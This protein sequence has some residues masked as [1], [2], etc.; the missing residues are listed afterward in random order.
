MQQYAVANANY[1]M[2][3][4]DKLPSFHAAPFLCGGITMVGALSLCDGALEDGDTLV[5]SG[6]GGG[7]GHLG[8]QIASN[9]KNHKRLNV[10]AIDTGSAKQNPSVELG[11]AAFIDFKTED[12]VKK[13]MELANGKGADA[14]IVI[15]EANEAFDQAL[16][17]LRF[18]GTM[19][20]VGITK[21]D[22]R[23]PI[24][25]TDLEHRGT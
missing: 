7:L 8:L 13:V 25:P 11:A 9:P 18:A 5:I 14:A 10:I 15:P 24:S 6:S 2:P 17:Y 19:I 16:K 21:M 20:C 22:Y 12:V 1:L 3:I 4:P 23:F